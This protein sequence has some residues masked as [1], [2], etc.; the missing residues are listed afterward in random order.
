IVVGTLVYVAAERR[1]DPGG[2]RSAEAER[3][4]DRYNPVADLGL[5]AVA[6]GHEGELAV[7]IDFQQREIGLF[8]AADDLG[9]M[10]AVVLR[11]TV[12]F[13]GVPTTW[14]LVRT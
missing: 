3:V 10:A 13:F 11:T 1:D 4:A 7:D 9:L 2:H 6:P 8:V 14:S 5:I 12:T